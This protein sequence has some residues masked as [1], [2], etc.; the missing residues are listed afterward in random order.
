MLSIP[1]PML[2]IVVACLVILAWA[3]LVLPHLPVMPGDPSFAP[4][5]GHGTHSIPTALLTTAVAALV[6]L[7]LAWGVISDLYFGGA[8]RTGPDHRL[9]VKLPSEQGIWAYSVSLRTNEVLCVQVTLTS[10]GHDK[11][12]VEMALL[13]S[14][15]TEGAADLRCPWTAATRCRSGS[16]YSSVLAPAGPHG[17]LRVAVRIRQPSPRDLQMR[18]TYFPTLSLKR[19]LRR[20][21]G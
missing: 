9:L 11:R 14:G 19:L 8:L 10:T 18:A 3:W 12:E 20:R 16:P 13:G 17:E 7:V 2:H 5:G 1:R 15:S 6:P 21:Y 4:L